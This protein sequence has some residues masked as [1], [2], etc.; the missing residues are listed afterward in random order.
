MNYASAMQTKTNGRT[1][2]D[3]WQWLKLGDVCEIIMGQSPEGNTYNSNREGAP[4]LNGPTEFGDKFPIPIQWTTSPTRFAEK[5]DILFCVRGATTGRKNIADQRYCIGRGLAAIRATKEKSNREFLYYLLDTVTSELLNETAG[6]IF[7][8]LSGEK[9]Q[10]LTVPLPPLDEQRRIA[11]QLNEQLAAVESA[12]KAAEEQLDL[13]YTLINAYLKESLSGSLRKLQLKDGFVE[14]KKGIGKTWADYALLG[15]TRYGVAPAKEKVG[16]QP[17]RY[18]LVEPGTIFYNPMRINIGSIG[19]LDEGGVPGITSPDYVVINA[20][21]G[22]I[23]PRWFYFWLRSPYGKAFIKTLARGAVRERM[24]FTRLAP[25]YLDIPSYEVQAEIAEKLLGI[26]Q[27][28]SAIESQLD[29][30]NR[31]PASLLREA[32]A[33]NMR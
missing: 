6:S 1:L 29:E 31:L 9:L 30:I 33:G 11:I 27:L 14:V 17:E 4:L 16:K 23:H 2:P 15:T 3:G 5:N 26:K 20:V 22:V 18:K 24:M 32:F 28:R 7:P 12:R 21:K 10:N 13:S 8:N 25:A 19:M